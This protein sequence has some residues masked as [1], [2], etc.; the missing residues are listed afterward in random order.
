MIC[1]TDHQTL[2]RIRKNRTTEVGIRTYRIYGLDVACDSDFGLPLPVSTNP[3]RLHIVHTDA[4]SP[5]AAEAPAPA[6]ASTSTV[7]QQVTFVFAAMADCDVVRVV[8]VAD[9]VLTDSRITCHQLDA[10][11]RALVPVHLF[12]MVLS[13]WLER[14]GILTLHASAVATEAGAI[15]ILA[16]KG[17]GKSTLAAALVAAGGAFLTD[18]LLALTPQGSTFLAHPAYPQLRMTGEQAVALTGSADDLP[19]VNPTTGKYGVPVARFGRFSRDPVPLLACYLPDRGS[20][21]AEVNI[22][23]LRPRE[24][25]LTLVRH[26]FLPQEVSELGLQRGRFPRLTTLAATVPFRRVSFPTGHSRL[27]GVVAQLLEDASAP[28][29]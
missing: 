25:F 29:G 10:R 7:G 19:V 9:Y 13:L 26:T 21:A 27:P 2:G 1:H 11:H 22:S 23:P 4:P 20:E 18:D 17:G 12:G 24:A 8:G 16:A 15:V 14:R 28:A 5:L 3:P 6:A